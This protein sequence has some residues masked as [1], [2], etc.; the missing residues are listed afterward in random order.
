MPRL[1]GVDLSR[2]CRCGTDLEPVRGKKG[3]ARPGKYL[4][5]VSFRSWVYICER[6]R[7]RHVARG[8]KRTATI[9]AKVE[10]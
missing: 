1:L 4:H 9:L 7:G 6:C 10:P 8:A 5:F 2:C 3:G